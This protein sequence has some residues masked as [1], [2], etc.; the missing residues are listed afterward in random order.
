MNTKEKTDKELTQIITKKFIYEAA[1][2]FK[3]YTFAEF[4]AD[5]QSLID[6][7]V[8]SERERIIEQLDSHLDGA[9]DPSLVDHGVTEDEIKGWANAIHF[10]VGDLRLRNDILNPTK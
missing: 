2:K 10:I 6:D 8:K 4:D 5:I 3:D 7:A 1:K 9:T